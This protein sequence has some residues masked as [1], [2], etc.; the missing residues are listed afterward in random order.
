M[1]EDYVNE[2][3]ETVVAETSS[4]DPKLIFDAKIKAVVCSV[5]RRTPKFAGFGMGAAHWSCSCVHDCRD[6]RGHESCAGCT[7]K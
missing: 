1:K 7:G 2:W 3:G 4:Y 6:E 5:C